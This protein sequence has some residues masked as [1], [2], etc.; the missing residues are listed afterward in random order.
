MGEGIH[1]CW[2]DCKNFGFLTAGQHKKWS[3]PIKTLEEGDIVVAFLKS[4]GYVGIGRVVEKAVRV[5]DFKVDGKSLKQYPI[6]ASD[7]FDNCDNGKSEYLVRIVWIEAVEGKDAKWKRNSG[8]FS[9]Q[10][11][12]ASLQGQPKTIEFLEKEFALTFRN[13]LL[14]DE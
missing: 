10:L 13:L 14:V 5:N 4:R 6:K 12:K 11:V 2:D 8:L 1:R 9:S 3:D 7:I